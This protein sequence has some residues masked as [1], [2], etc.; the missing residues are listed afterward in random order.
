MGN[1][2]TRITPASFSILSNAAVIAVN[3]DPMGSNAV[4]RWTQAVN[5]TDAYG[6]GSIQLWS[7]PL[8]STT[9]G[10]Q[11]DYV[12][13]LLNGGN[14]SRTM[15]ATLADIFIDSG[16]SGTAPEV[17]LSWE[18]RDLWAIRLSDQAAGA[19]VNAANRTVTN[20]T[21]D[22]FGNETALLYN[23]TQQSYAEG[24]AKADPALLGKVS[25]TV[26]ASGTI[27]A[28]VAPHGVVMLRLRA[29]QTA[30]ARDEL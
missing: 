2:F 14:S 15:N 8:N 19:I 4:R 23:A 7:G 25:T 17:K 24:I 22:V 13:V 3:Q 1:D 20:G 10:E 18:V 6:Q 29:V 28:S 12:V 5:D 11:D 30:M 16:T 9:G 21:V 26:P 27:T